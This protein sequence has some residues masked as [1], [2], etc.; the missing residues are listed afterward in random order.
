MHTLKHLAVAAAMVGLVAPAQA[1]YYPGSTDFEGDSPLADACWSNLVEAVI[2]ADASVAD[3]P[4]SPNLPSSFDKTSRTNVLSFD[5][6]APIV[7]YLQSDRTAPSASTIYADILVKGVPYPAGTPAPEA[8]ADAKIIVYT[9]ISQSGSETNLCVYAKNAADGTAQEFV[10]TKTIGIDEWHRLVVKATAA[11]Y[12]VYCDGT[13]AADLCKTADDV[14]T[15]YALSAGAPITSLAFSGTGSVDDLVL[16][17]FDPA[18][19]VY[20]LTWGE[21]FDSVSFTTNGVAGAALVPADGEYQFQAPEGLEVVLTGNTGYRTIEVSVTGSSSAISLEGV[22]GIAKYFPQTATAGQDGSAENPFEI[23]NLAALQA[24]QA[25]V[26]DTTNCFGLCFLQTA[27]IAMDAPWP[28]IGIPN[29]KDIYNT[30]EFQN[31]AFR[32]TYDGGNFTVSN[33]QMVGVAGNPASETEGLDYCGFFNSAYQATICNLKI[34]YAGDRFAADTTASTKE[35]GATFVGVANGSTLRNLTTL[36]GTV[37]CSKGFG[38]IS[39]YT[40]S[41]TVIDS[42]TNNVNMTSLANNKCGG[43][44]MITQ[45]GSAVTISNCQNN[46]TMT[47]GSSNSEYGAIVGYVGLNTTI[48]DCETTVGRFLKHQSGTV[49]LQGVN[50]GDATVASYHGM[51]TPGLNFATVEGNVATFVA[52]DALAAGNT[53]KV[54]GPSATATFAFAE[55]GTIAFDEA[56]S[57]PTYAITAPGLALTDATDGTVKTYTAVAITAETWIGGDSGNWNAAD[58]WDF[59]YVPTK[60][61]V[62]TFTNDAQAAIFGSDRCKEL[63]LSNANVTLVR[64][65]NATQ[66]ILQ[67]YGDEGRA[68]SVASGATGS[69]SVNGLALFNERKDKNDMT[70]GCAF[71]ILGDVTFRG[72]S[73]IDDSLSASFTITN[74]TT[75]SANALVKTIDYG[76]TK[77]L[78]GIEVAKGVKAK[79]NTTAHGSAQIG[80]G[81]TLVANDGEGAATTIWLMRN[82]ASSRGVSLVNGA[83]VSVDAAHAGDCYVKKDTDVMNGIDCDVYE[84]CWNP[85]VFVTANGMTV[86]GVENEQK[87]VP[88]TNLVINVSGFAEGYEPS[89]TIM[90]HED[91]DYSVLLTTNAVSFTY[92]MPDF[93]ID[94]VAYATPPSYNDP[95]GYEITDQG[96]IDWLL[97]NGFT[98]GDIDAL[99]NDTAATDKLYECW[100]LNCSINAANPGGTISATGIAVTNG[101]IS[102]TVRLDR[103]SPLGFISGVLHIYGTDDLADDFSLISDEI[104]YISDGDSIFDTEPA[105]GAVTQSVTATFSPTDVT[106]KFFRAV[107]EF[108]IPGDPEEDPLEEPEPDPEE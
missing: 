56:L 96:L 69:L 40:T 47:T 93:D 95:E 31:G 1:E 59:G 90:K 17:D 38:G 87:V 51:A 43:I 83:K 6:D 21:G 104:V 29:G 84:A 49:T 3:L 79:I 102:I 48:A 5:T 2:E 75:I 26:A 20:T 65:A 39:G 12:Q 64:A 108:P 34:A 106:A 8:G 72:I 53:Y 18:L 62:V 82:V 22:S 77:F 55:P 89:V 94:V 60:D 80:T 92:T 88:G 67:F 63:V 105:E 71:E 30:D 25:M 15:F 99:G 66:P 91:E 28:G 57:A 36:A 10:L 32:G 44:A 46:G 70:I 27:D 85:T 76:M 68:V 23:P 107:I 4:R 9:R 101:V 86:T 37:S 100:V 97:A 42:C 14:D 7:R 50:K 11:G 103:Q 58:N 74:K 52:D 33:F 81:V 78:G 41:G 54:M 98:Q 73:I 24:L 13:D 61:T 35:S 19:S 45:G 16:S